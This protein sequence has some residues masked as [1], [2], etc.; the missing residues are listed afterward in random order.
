VNII[1]LNI[2]HKG[3]TMKLSDQALGAIMM[4]L[5]KAIAEEVDIVP[6][7]KDFNFDKATTRWGGN[8][9]LCVKNP[10]MS[11]TVKTSGEV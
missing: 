1:K 6:I 3:E 11:F 10:P 4:A 9:E 2:A 7:L 8:G 5:Q